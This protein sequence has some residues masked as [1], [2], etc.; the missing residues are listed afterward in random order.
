[1]F[2]DFILFFFFIKYLYRP[3]LFFGSIGIVTLGI[4]VLINIYLLILKLMGNDIWGKPILLLGILLVLGGIQ[5]ITTGI[6]AELQMR[7]YFESQKKK[8]FRVKRVVVAK[9]D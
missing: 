5:F 4:G 6:V 1:L 8:P 9:E 2:I 7:T 3:I